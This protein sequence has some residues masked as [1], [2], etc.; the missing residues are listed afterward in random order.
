MALGTSLALAGILHLGLVLG[1]ERLCIIESIEMAALEIK[2]HR[3]K[4]EMAS[5]PEH[6]TFS[7][8]QG[9]WDV[10][11]AMDSRRSWVQN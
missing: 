11:W 7:E 1:G 9:R 8:E 3:T 6:C 4:R 2:F 10:M 5:L